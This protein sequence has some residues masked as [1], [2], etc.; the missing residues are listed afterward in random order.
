MRIHIPKMFINPV[1]LLGAVVA[2]VAL[3]AS[4]VALTMDLFAASTRPY[5]GILT[6]FVFP[7]F[8]GMGLLVIAL[9][10]LIE[11]NRLRKGG[12]GVPA[13]PVLDFNQPKERRFYFVF[14]VVTLVIVLLSILGSYRA[15]EFTDSVAFCGQLCHTVME[16]E[17]TAYQ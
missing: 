16:P 7:A 12:A 9:G 17:F 14:G 4:T 8:L 15:Y 13:F 2:T 5:Q 6:F 11:R 10:A 3:G 1:S